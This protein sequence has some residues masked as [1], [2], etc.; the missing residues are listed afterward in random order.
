MVRAENK[1]ASFD[2]REV[3]THM[4]PDSHHTAIDLRY[5]R[6]TKA[7]GIPRFECKVPEEGKL[8]SK[9]V[10][11]IGQR[12]HGDIPGEI[13][14]AR[15]PDGHLSARKLKLRITRLICHDLFSNEPDEDLRTV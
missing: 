7:E 3:D 13:S 14:S 1:S 10:V 5:Q 9:V 11:A 6:Y 15:N 12:Y 4:Y 2:D 8:L